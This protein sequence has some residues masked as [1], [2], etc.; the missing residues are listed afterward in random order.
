MSLLL[1]VTET[2]VRRSALVMLIN[3]QLVFCSADDQL[4]ST[5][6]ITSLHYHDDS[7]KELF[8]F[9]GSDEESVR[10][11][12]PSR[13]SASKTSPHPAEEVPQHPIRDLTCHLHTVQGKELGAGLLQLGS[14]C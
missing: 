8:C 3:L 12:S 4:T 2:A 6:E 11:E 1:Q 5:G 14:R 9:S 13:A 10:G 7:K